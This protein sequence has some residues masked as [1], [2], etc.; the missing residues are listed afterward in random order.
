[1]MIA[2]VTWG[3]IKPGKWDEF[4][5][6]WNDFA[7]S[8]KDVPGSRGRVLLREDGNKDSGY[9]ISFWDSAAD[10]DAHE[11][12]HD[13]THEKM[14][15]IRACFVGQYVTTVTELSGSTLALPI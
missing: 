8:T 13:D 12:M 3:K 9:S 5:R 1:M 6:L 2:R 10:F 14:E 4:A 11:R 15:A 7:T